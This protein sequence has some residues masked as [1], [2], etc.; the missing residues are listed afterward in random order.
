MVWFWDGLQFSSVSPTEDG[1]VVNN[2]LSE[3]EKAT[4]QVIFLEIDNIFYSSGN[5]F[6]NCS[7]A[8]KSSKPGIAFSWGDTNQNSYEQLFFICFHFGT[9]NFEHVWLQ[10]W[11]YCFQNLYS[12]VFKNWIQTQFCLVLKIFFLFGECFQNNFVKLLYLNSAENTKKLFSKKLD[13]SNARTVFALEIN[14]RKQLPNIT[15]RGGAAN[16]WIQ[17]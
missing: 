8:L 11:V 9:N 10:F 16:L 15:T 7:Q 6:G 1:V 13:L 2:K 4:L 17:I 5:I 3:E 12:T 14:I